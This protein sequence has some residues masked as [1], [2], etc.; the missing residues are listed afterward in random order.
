MVSFLSLVSS[1]RL[2]YIV[3]DSRKGMPISADDDVQRDCGENY[4]TLPFSF[5]SPFPVSL[6][7]RVFGTRKLLLGIPSAALGH[8]YGDAK[9]A[10][11]FTSVRIK[12]SV[13]WLEEKT[14]TVKENVL[15]RKRR[16]GGR[17]QHHFRRRFVRPIYRSSLASLRDDLII[18][19]RTSIAQRKGEREGGGEVDRD[20]VRRGG[21]R[22]YT[23]EGNRWEGIST[24]AVNDPRAAY[25][26]N[27]T[28]IVPDYPRKIG[29]F[30]LLS[31]LARPKNVGSLYAGEIA[32]VSCGRISIRASKQKKMSWPLRFLFSR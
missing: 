10:R 11:N 23:P 29:D 25:T 4:R 19:R 22:D 13:G 30:D 26:Y 1:P 12:R 15:E 31:R 6:G 18:G 2:S 16:R 28:G 3:S 32:R 17:S 5:S 7:G 27:A 14:P 21:V 9:R 20:D 24:N 8:R